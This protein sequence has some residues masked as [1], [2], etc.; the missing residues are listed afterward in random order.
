MAPLKK[1]LFKAKEH[2]DRKRLLAVFDLD[3]TVFD[4]SPRTQFILRMAGEDSHFTKIYPRQSQILK[5][6]EVKS[7]DWGIKNALARSQIQGTIDFFE[8]IQSYWRKY[9][10][11]NDYLKHDEPY[12][13]AIEYIQTLHQEGARIIYLT[14]R[15]IKRMGSGTAETLQHWGLPID[16]DHKL[17]LKPEKGM[18][19]SH[20][21][22]DVMVE[23]QAE[24]EEIWL[25]ENEPVNIALIERD[26]PDVKII[27]L[28]TVHSGRIDTPTHHPTLPMK[29]HWEE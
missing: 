6:I 22:R 12:E 8:E 16:E 29:Y 18:S 7:T 19:D 26:C 15:D 28:D 1:V 11:H 2:K 21:K 24:H 25:F 27:F 9:F 14:G 13:G 23:L 20:F 17:I 5:T 4:V 3:S 10:F